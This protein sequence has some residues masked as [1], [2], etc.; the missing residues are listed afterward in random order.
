[1]TIHENIQ[2][3]SVT[4]VLQNLLWNGLRL[5][6]FLLNMFNTSP[7]YMATYSVC[8]TVLPNND[9]TLVRHHADSQSLTKGLQLLLKTL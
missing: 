5:V 8:L 6:K 4:W 9:E 7:I 3:L 1:M 2:V